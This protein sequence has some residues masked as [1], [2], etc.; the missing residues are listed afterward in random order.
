[1]KAVMADSA[2]PETPNFNKWLHHAFAAA[3]RLEQ[4]G[5]L[6]TAL[7]PHDQLSQ[8][9]VLVQLEHLASYMIV[10]ERILAG[11][12]R[13]SGWWFDVASGSMY[14][15]DRSS[16]SFEVIDRRMAERMGAYP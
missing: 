7:K 8:L 1:M 2:R 4:E 14:A 10:R 12:L 11:T 13:L 9:N 3:F 5:A 6:D 15:Y 16:R